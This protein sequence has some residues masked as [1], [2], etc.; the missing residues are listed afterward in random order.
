[1]L[2]T[3]D[4]TIN[5]LYFYKIQQFD[6]LYS[7]A[8]KVLGSADKFYLIALYNNLE[9][10]Y[11]V[12]STVPKQIKAQGSGYFY[13]TSISGDITIPLGT[14][15]YAP[16]DEFTPFVRKYQT[17]ETVSLTGQDLQVDVEIVA[18][19]YGEKYNVVEN[20]ITMV[21]FPTHPELKFTNP[22]PILNAKDRKVKH[23][24]EYL[25][26][27]AN[28][29]TDFDIREL[30]PADEFYDYSVLGADIRLTDGDIVPSEDSDI[31]SA[32]IDTVSG[33]D[34]IKQALIYK[35]ITPKGSLRGHPEYG[36]LLSYL[37]GNF[38]GNY[39]AEM[40]KV[41]TIRTLLTDPRVSEVKFV[42]VSIKSNTAEIDFGITLIGSNQIIQDNLIIKRP[43]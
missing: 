30:Q 15:V 6:T 38:S 11:I 27:P 1:M 21:D 42:T 2:Y 39:L 32:D 36:S 8:T 35:L 24:G 41:E 28:L 40:I 3:Q 18:V 31:G 10:P 5:N 22:E 43:S 13:R 19:D 23:P 7:I 12:P 26:I 20:K 33:L 37:L 25:I 14:V 17:L 34:N 29:I 16:A 4:N 9:P